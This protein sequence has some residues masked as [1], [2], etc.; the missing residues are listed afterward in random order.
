MQ[1]TPR[2][3]VIKAHVLKPPKIVVRQND[4]DIAIQKPDRV[5]S[6]IGNI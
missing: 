5:Y 6:E 4:R 2:E 3:M 1:L